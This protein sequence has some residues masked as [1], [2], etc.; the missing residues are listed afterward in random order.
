MYFNCFSDYIFIYSKLLVLELY[1][2]QKRRF[3]FV[4]K[5]VKI[6]FGV[7]SGRKRKFYN[8]YDMGV[9]KKNQIIIFII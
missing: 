9:F 2:V 7:L 8:I 6:K 4:E 1:R 5:N 3:F